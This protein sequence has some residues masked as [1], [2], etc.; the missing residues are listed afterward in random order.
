[1]TRLRQIAMAGLAAIAIG[2]VA[3][4]ASAMEIWNVPKPLERRDHRSAARCSRRRPASIRA[5]KR[6]T[7]ACGGDNSGHSTGN[8]C[9]RRSLVG[10]VLPC[11]PSLRRC[12]CSGCRAG[13]SGAPPIRPRWCK[14]S[15]SSRRATQPGSGGNCNGTFRSTAAASC[16]PT[17]SVQPDHPVVETGRRLVH[18]GRLH[19]HVAERHA[20]DRHAEPRLLDV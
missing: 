6:L 12:R 5:W 15:T 17:R 3:S 14:P 1:M 10:A 20:H 11:P 18:V 4:S 2:G 19:L 13:I 16:T 7:S 8:Q 9:A